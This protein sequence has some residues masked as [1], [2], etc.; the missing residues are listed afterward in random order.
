MVCQTLYNKN[1]TKFD[2]KQNNSMNLTC[3]CY[4]TKINNGHHD[5]EETF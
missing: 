4:K 1:R 5:S 2:D 3:F